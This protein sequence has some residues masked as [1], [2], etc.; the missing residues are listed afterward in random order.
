MTS[1]RLHPRPAF[2][3]CRQLICGSL[4]FVA[5]ALGGNLWAAATQD[6]TVNVTLTIDANIL[7]YWSDSAGTVGTQTTSA[8]A[9][10]MGSG[11]A[12]N[13][14][15]ETTA[16][17][18]ATPQPT[19]PGLQYIK[20][21][22]NCAVDIAAKCGNSTHWNVGPTAA[23]NTFEMSVNQALGAYTALSTTLSAAWISN[24][25]NGSVSSLIGLRLKTPTAITLG[26][27]RQQTIVVTF[28]AS[29]N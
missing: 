18:G 10:S 25:T 7:V 17:G 16:T 12:L 2:A 14:V 20:N 15:Y 27:G 5:S 22:S 11:I 21:I 1:P 29:P 23:N 13:T 3:R 8:Q 19:V 9:W 4:L 28:T 24:L 26:G 6:M